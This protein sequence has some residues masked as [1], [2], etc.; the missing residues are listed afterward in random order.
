MRLRT[1]IVDIVSGAAAIAVFALLWELVSRLSGGFIRTLP[2][3]W[4]VVRSYRELI[5]SGQLASDTGITL[6]R[7][8]VGWAAGSACGII[9]GMATATIPPVRR[10]LHPVIQALRPVTPVGIAPLSLAV[11]GLTEFSKIFVVSWGVFFVVW[12][13]VHTAVATID[14]RLISAARTLG[15]RRARLL[16]E[17]YP[18]AGFNVILSG[19]RTGISIAFI[20]VVVAEM[21]GAG[22]SEGLGYRIALAYQ[23]FRIDQM[24]ALLAVVGLLGYLADAGFIAAVRYGFPWARLRDL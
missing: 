16:A 2:G 22:A 15:A 10:F 18:F 21:M 4:T 19:L 3:P 1:R 13:A 23:V 5:R 7:L 14:Q 17:V 6:L 8:A 9:A 12:V 20:C 11:F 24:I